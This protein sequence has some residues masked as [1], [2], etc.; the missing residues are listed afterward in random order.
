ME[1][2][3]TSAMLRSRIAQLEPGQV[4]IQ[5]VSDGHIQLVWR[6][7]N[8]PSERPQSPWGPWIVVLE[9][10]YGQS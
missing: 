1:L 5:I 9:Y 10:R 7:R 8:E 2:T 3:R 6:K 4:Q